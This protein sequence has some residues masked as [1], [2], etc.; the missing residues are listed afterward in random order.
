MK[1]NLKGR[2]RKVVAGALAVALSVPSSIFMGG[3]YSPS[4]TKQAKAASGPIAF[5]VGSGA[6]IAPAFNA[7]NLPTYY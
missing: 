1:K 4:V 7:G 3:G 2:L 6:A 5:E